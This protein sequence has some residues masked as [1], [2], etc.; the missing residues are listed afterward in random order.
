MAEY[1]ERNNEELDRRGGYFLRHMSAMTGD[2]LHSKSAIAGELGWRDMQIADLQHTLKELMSIVKIH[3][4]ATDN[5]FAW[6]EMEE[7]ERVLNT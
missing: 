7:A 5:D 4:E 6:A 2:G 3:S 1:R